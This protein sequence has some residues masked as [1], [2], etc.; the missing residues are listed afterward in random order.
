MVM[1]FV[2]SRRPIL[3]TRNKRDGRLGNARRAA[4]GRLMLRDRNQSTRSPQRRHCKKTLRR[5]NQETRL[6]KGARVAL[7]AK[8]ETLV[9]VLSQ[10]RLGDFRWPVLL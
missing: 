10:S 1:T 5:T 2:P 4:T 3:T 9:V 7:W 6:R 8:N